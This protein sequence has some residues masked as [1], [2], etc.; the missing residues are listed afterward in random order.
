VLFPTDERVM[1]EIS[2]YSGNAVSLLF[3]R[4]FLDRTRAVHYIKG[5][6]RRRTEEGHV[7]RYPS[8]EI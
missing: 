4:S 6:I 5:L 1:V 2:S 3:L 8:K 7:K